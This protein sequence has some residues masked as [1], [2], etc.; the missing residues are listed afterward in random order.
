MEKR[1]HRARRKG[2]WPIQL[3]RIEALK[4]GSVEALN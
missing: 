1:L 4:G 2:G 3:A